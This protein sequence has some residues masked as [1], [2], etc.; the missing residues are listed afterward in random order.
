MN[1]STPNGY[2]IPRLGVQVV[3]P[4]QALDM[5]VKAFETNGRMT[6]AMGA[7]QTGVGFFL[8][9]GREEDI[10]PAFERAMQLTQTAIIRG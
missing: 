6:G 7:L 9:V 3:T 2:N 1:D 4:H 10:R 8:C 5:L